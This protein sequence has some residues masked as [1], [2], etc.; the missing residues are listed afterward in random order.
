[1]HIIPKVSAYLVSSPTEI[2]HESLIGRKDGPTAVQLIHM[3]KDRAALHFARHTIYFY[4]FFFAHA[5]MG[6]K[7]PD[8]DILA[9]FL[10]RFKVVSY[11]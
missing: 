9:S 6:L 4:V 3:H 7:K 5:C 10:I 2:T 8:N 11:K 1:M